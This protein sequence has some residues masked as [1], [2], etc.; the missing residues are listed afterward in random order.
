MI[1]L[2]R[3]R[4]MDDWYQAQEIKP[5]WMMNLSLWDDN[6][7]IGTVI[8]GGVM[9]RSS[10]NGIGVGITKEGKLGIGSPWAQDWMDYVTAYPPMIAEGKLTGQKVDSYVQ[11]AKTRRIAFCGAGDTFYTVSADALTLNAFAHQLAERGFYVALN[12]D[13][14]GSARQ[15]EGGRAINSPTDNRKIPVMLAVWEEEK[16][17]RK[18]TPEMTYDICL[19][20]GHGAETAGKRS[21][22]QKY[23]EYEF[24]RD[25]C[26]RIKA[27]LERC[28]LKVTQTTEGAEDMPLW[29]RCEAANKSGAKAVVSIHS[30]AENERTVAADG[31]GTANYWMAAVIAKGGQAEKLA[32]SIRKESAAALKIKDNGVQECNYQILRDT[33]APAVL[34]EHG[35][36]THKEWTRTMLMTDEGRAAM[37]ECD[38]K[39]IVAYCGQKWIPAPNESE[40]AWYEKEL[41]EAVAAGITDGTRPEEPATRAE[42]AVM[43]LRS[44]KKEV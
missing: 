30:N 9:A 35:F 27:H 26:R 43:V 42:V 41:A 36:H 17:E 12:Y 2:D 3:K 33:R 18:E 22:D 28:G 23:F 8:R 13:G 16:E 44:M 6:G 14:G 4:T 40:S 21:P 34:I 1:W 11:N 7:P 25:L 37:A 24:A 10:G 19:D 31:W 38:A 39:G 20:P 15:Y 29:K 5:K 32:E